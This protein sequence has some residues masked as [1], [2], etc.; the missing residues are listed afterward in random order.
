[1]IL[2]VQKIKEITRGVSFIEEK[3]GQ[4]VFHRF[5]REQLLAYEKQTRSADFTR[6]SLSTS[7]VR[8]EFSTDATAIAFK[9]AVT[10][11]SSRKFYNFDIYVDGYMADHLGGTEDGDFSFESSLGEGKKNVTVYF[12]WSADAHISQVEAIGASF[13]E[14]A[15]RKPVMLSYGDSIT[16]GYDAM[17]PSLSYASVIADRMGVEALNKGIGGEFFCP[18]L[19][20]KAEELDVKYITV[21]YGTND[22]SKYQREDFEEN[23]RTFYNRLFELYPNAKIFAVTPIWREDSSRRVTGC[24]K[25]ESV[26]DFIAGVC[27]GRENVFVIDGPTLTPHYTEFYSD[28]YLHPNDLGFV[29]YGNNLYEKIKE[30]I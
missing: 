29:I 4:I 20:E 25:L 22:W 15:E 23:C 3:D 8:F 27:E 2:D 5:S 30:H 24:G 21:A 14:G 10:G 13:V 9:G 19:L 7:G 18:Y 11:G 26:R 12:P 16:Q 17:Y 1:M 6:K 28:K